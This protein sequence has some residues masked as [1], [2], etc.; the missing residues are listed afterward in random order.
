MKKITV[1]IAEDHVVVREGFRKMLE[2]EDDLEVIG[3]AQDGRQAVA[4]FNRG[5]QDA[6]MS[7]TL[8]QLGAGTPIIRDLWQR[9]NVTG[10]TT[11]SP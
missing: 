3:E 6:T 8:T 2:L 1:L 9:A 7:V 5:R 11:G 4:L 10:M